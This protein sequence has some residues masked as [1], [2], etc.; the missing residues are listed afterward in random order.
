MIRVIESFRDFGFSLAFY[1]GT[2]FILPSLPDVTV[3]KVS[4]IPSPIVESSELFSQ[5]FILF[6][7]TF[8]QKQIFQGYVGRFFSGLIVF[9]SLS[10]VLV[11]IVVIAF[12]CIKAILLEPNNKHGKLTWPLKVHY[13][14]IRRIYNPVKAWIQ[15]FVEFLK[16]HKFYIYLGLTIWLLNLNLITIVMET[17]SFL[18]YFA[19]SFDFLNIGIQGFKLLND[20]YYAWNGLP[21]IFWILILAI[22]FDS[23]RKKKGYER[24]QRMELRNRGLIKSLSIVSF[25]VGTMNK[26]KTTVITDMAL[27]QSVMFRDDA[28]KTLYKIELKYPDFP[29]IRLEKDLQR[30]FESGRIKNLAGCKKFINHLL[31]EFPEQSLEQIY[32]YNLDTF[33]VSFDD[34]LKQ[35]II[36]D[37]L[38][39]YAEAYFIY[40]GS[41]YV[42]S[43]YSIRLDDQ[44]RNS[45]NFPKW[46]SDFF[47]RDSKKI[48]QMSRFSKILDFDVLR[49]GKT[50]VENNIISGSFEFGVLSITEIGKERLNK[51]EMEGVKKGESK[52]N[53]KNDLFNTYVKMCRHPSTVDYSPYIK[54]FVDDQRP[55]SWGA[56]ARDLSMIVTIREADIEE[57]IVLPFFLWEDY[58]SEL[59]INKFKDLYYQFR[60]L[61]GDNCLFMHFLKSMI[62]MLFKYRLRR[63]NTFGY[64]IVDLDIERGTQDGEIKK[65]EYYLMNKKI[66]AERFS[67]DCFAGFF[68]E[69]ALRANYGL[70]DYA[71]YKSVK[72]SFEEL[73][74]QNS[75][76]VRSMENNLKNEEEE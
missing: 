70:S 51:P 1:F 9:G 75:Y 45:G 19:V 27:S 12:A 44:M 5:R 63:F 24:L 18:F 36:F 62:S 58:L 67:T 14:F 57:R 55:E 2:I 61:R 60:F 11:L 50:V 35:S 23:W 43:N 48:Y 25:I 26:K 22:I 73:L 34:H 69:K 29:F 21:E 20:L 31:E 40:V 30:F 28:L 41:N 68:E 37:D 33:P 4:S 42:V 72:A 66:Y 17:I 13:V 10:I 56:D 39:T 54:F 53:Q 49:L 59:T 16:G 46:N 6:W 71:E 32:N 47:H 52:A 38:I 74:K 65:K 3:T 15:S 64:R 7:E 8:I 76:F